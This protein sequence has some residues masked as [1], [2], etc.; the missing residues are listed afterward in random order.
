MRTLIKPKKSTLR[1]AAVTIALCLFQASMVNA[2]A[3]DGLSNTVSVAEVLIGFGH[4]QNLRITVQNS[5]EGPDQRSEHVEPLRMQV[6]LSDQNGRVLAESA[7]VEIPPGEFRSV[8]FSRD[9]IPLA[10]E[11]SGRLQ[12][13]ATCNIK[14]REAGTRPQFKASLEVL[15]SAGGNDSIWIDLSLPVRH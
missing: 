11:A 2:S 8:D 1:L 9:D 13:R 10:G 14:V 5:S 6:R 12:V 15:N 3:S 7:E 4:G